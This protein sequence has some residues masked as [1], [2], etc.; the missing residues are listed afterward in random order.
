MHSPAQQVEMASR[1]AELDYFGCDGRPWDM[2]EDGKWA[3]SGES[4]S[5]KGKVLIGKGE[6]FLEL[7]R[8]SGKKSLFLMEN[9]NLPAKMIPAMDAGFRACWR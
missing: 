8:Q 5:G 7:A 2:A 1:I 9:H 6:R 4:E 3:G